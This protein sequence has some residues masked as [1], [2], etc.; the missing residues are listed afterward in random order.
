[1]DGVFEVGRAQP[2][3]IIIAI[4]TVSTRHALLRV[5]V[6]HAWL[7]PILPSGGGI[8]GIRNDGYDMLLC[9]VPLQ[10]LAADSSIS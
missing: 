8:A 4:P 2:A 5:G 6:C 1:M 10:S 9:L 3:D 7:V